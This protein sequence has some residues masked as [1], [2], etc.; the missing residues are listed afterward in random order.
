MRSCTHSQTAFCFFGPR[1]LLPT[2]TAGLVAHAAGSTPCCYRD[3]SKLGGAADELLLSWTAAAQTRSRPNA[4]NDAVL[5]IIRKAKN[6]YDESFRRVLE[7]AWGERR[8]QA[9]FVFAPSV[10]LQIPRDFEYKPTT[11]VADVLDL[12]TGT[13]CAPRA[14]AA[15]PT[16]CWTHNPSKLGGDTDEFLSWASVAQDPK[17]SNLKATYLIFIF[18]IPSRGARGSP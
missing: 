15:S 7:M 9:L 14:H 11:L 16:L 12:P 17:P 10:F 4:Q 6:Y 1:V 13:Y 3:P 5:V 2:H 18:Y 8:T